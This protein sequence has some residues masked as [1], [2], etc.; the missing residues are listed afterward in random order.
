MTTTDDVHRILAR[1]R[2]VCRGLPEA[3]EQEAWVGTR[4]RVRGRTFAHVLE[5]VDG[6]PPAYAKA[7]GTPGPA[8]LLMFRSSGPEL[9]ALRHGGHPYFGPPWRSDEVGMILGAESGVATGTGTGASVD[10]DE[11]AELLTESYCLCAPRKLARLVDR[12]GT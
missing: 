5:V 1:V 12:P 7:A 2:A 11:V 4:W 6:W 3:H 10:E 8:W 9:D